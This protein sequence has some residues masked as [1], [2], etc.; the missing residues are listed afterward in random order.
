MTVLAACLT[1]QAAQGLKLRPRESAWADSK[2]TGIRQPQGVA[3]GADGLVLV[4]DTGNGR[5]VRYRWSEKGIQPEGETTLP[6][7]SAPQRVRFDPDGTILVLDG[8]QRKIGRVAADGRFAG[9]LDWAGVTGPV[10]P[11]SFAVDREGTMFVLDVAAGRVLVF[12]RPGKLLRTI[13]L[14]EH[15]GFVSDVA[16]DPAGTVYVVDSVDRSI[17]VAAKDAASARPLTTSLGQEMDFPSAIT[18]DSSGRLL[19][20][21]QNGGG[22]LTLGR[23]GSFLGR[24]SGFGWKEGLLRYPSDLCLDGKGKIFV[25]D[26]A[27]NRVQVFEIVE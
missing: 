27:N 6:E 15:Y 25:S 14:P 24:Q 3:C 12:D 13:G 8:N 4:A 22:I 11:R 16:V 18:I 5:L 1:V 10:V 7:L 9:Y 2:G 23:D 20:L 26:R 21:D 17:L 19:V